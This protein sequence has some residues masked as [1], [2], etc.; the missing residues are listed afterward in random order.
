[1]T[2]ISDA[3]HSIQLL[4]TE[5]QIVEDRVEDAKKKKNTEMDRRSMAVKLLFTFQP[6]Q[7]HVL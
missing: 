5:M 6:N 7:P 1:M 3:P 4:Q 2:H